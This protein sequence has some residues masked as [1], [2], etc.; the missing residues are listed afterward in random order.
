MFFTASDFIFTI[1]HIHNWALFLLW[2]SLFILSRA[3][4]LFFRIS[5]LDTYWP[6]GLIFRCYIFLP[7]HTVHGVLKARILKWFKLVS[8]HLLW[9]TPFRRKM[10]SCTFFSRW[11]NNCLQWRTQTIKRLISCL[12]LSFV[13]EWCCITDF[14]EFKHHFA[15]FEK[16]VFS[17]FDCHGVHYSFLQ[18]LVLLDVT[19]DQSMVDEGMAREVINRIQKLR[20]KVSLWN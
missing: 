17:M 8:G 1:R 20:K 2:R 14:E 16:T 15:E 6:G 19:P 11:E 12:W 13:I 4:S 7:F 10:K 9:A 5:I 18:V 3:I